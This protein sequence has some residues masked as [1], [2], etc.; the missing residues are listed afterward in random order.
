MKRQDYLLIIII[1]SVL[2]PFFIP[3]TGFFDGFNRATAAH[4]FIMA[5]LKFAILA[6]L[7]ESIALRIRKGVYYEKGFG[8]APRILAGNKR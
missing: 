1:L 2:T 5:F 7:G 3:A 6:T 4:P 8:I